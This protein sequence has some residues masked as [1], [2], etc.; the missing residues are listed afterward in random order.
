MLALSEHVWFHYRLFMGVPVVRYFGIPFLFLYFVL[1][2]L[3]GMWFVSTCDLSNCRLG[4]DSLPEQVKT[5]LTATIDDGHWT[6]PYFDCGGGDVWMVTFSSPIF[7]IEQ[8]SGNP[9]FQ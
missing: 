7:A 8:P 2:T 1:L 9:N 4:N 6:K 3:S 5:V